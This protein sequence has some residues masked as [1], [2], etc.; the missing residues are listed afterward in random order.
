MVV[1][2]L[3]CGCWLVDWL[4][5]WLAGSAGSLLADAYVLVAWWLRGGCLSVVRWSVDWCWCE[6]VVCWLFGGCGLVVYRLCAGRLIGAGVRW[7]CAGCSA[8]AGWLCIGC[9]LVV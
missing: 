3:F 8:V 2:W 7:L 6:L 5:V 1:R 9:A 4:G